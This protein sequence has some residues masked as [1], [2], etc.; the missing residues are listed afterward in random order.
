MYKYDLIVSGGGLSGVAAAVAAAK[1]GLNVLLIE[2]SGSLGGALSNNLVFPF[3]YYACTGSEG[4]EK[5][6]LSQGLFSEMRKRHDEKSGTVSNLTFQTEY[7]KFALDDMVEEYGVTVLF[8]SSVYDVKTEN[9]NVKSVL[10]ANKG[11]S[12]EFEADFFIDATG[13]GDVMYLAGC[14]CL[15]GRED[16][17][18]TQPMTTCFRLCGVD[19]EKFAEDKE[20]LNI[21]YKEY[22]EQGKIK[23]PRENILTF[24]G[25]GEGVLHFNTTRVV[26]LNPVDPFDKSKAE[27]IA[28]KQIFEIVDFLKQNSEAFKKCTLISVANEIG[29]RESRKLKG[30]HVITAEELFNSVKFEDSIALGNYDIDIHSPDG[31]GTE[32]KTFTKKKYYYIPYRSL[33]PKEFDNLLVA[34]RC[35]STTHS[36]QSSAR[37]L[38]IVA[39]V[40]EAAG[41]AIAVA[42]NTNTN[43]HTLNVRQL[44]NTLIENGAE[45][46]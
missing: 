36:A 23:N 6:I 45:I 1:Q 11:G 43:T 7:F 24:T 10:V 2:K 46:F 28:R 39:C 4:F 3:C 44:Q 35:L 40:G 25:A 34:G 22:R 38:P 30:E 5:K 12:M 41:T 8:H 29:I 14:E 21:L 42:F 27:I 26:K 31:T 19:L 20:R 16:D 33:L 32:I 17:N 18:L 15:L 9:R 37:T 13:D